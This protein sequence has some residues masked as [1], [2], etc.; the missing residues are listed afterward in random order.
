[1]INKACGGKEM[2]GKMAA[3]AKWRQIV[4]DLKLLESFEGSQEEMERLKAA[5]FEVGLGKER[6]KGEATK[7]RVAGT[8]TKFFGGMQQRS[9]AEIIRRKSLQHAFLFWR[10]GVGAGRDSEILGPLSAK[11][12]D[13]VDNYM[14]MFAHAFNKV[15][16][17]SS[18][19]A[20]ASVSV[21]HMV[22]GARGN[23]F[24]MDRKKHE[25]FTVYG[26]SVRRVSLG[27]GIV[28]HVARTGESVMVDMIMDERFDENVDGLLGFER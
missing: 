19:F 28:G 21:A 18:L 4:R 13:R 12:V 8:L 24:L 2:K 15:G 14:L 3:L 9:D 10:G 22:R 1:M 20:V 6:T 16:Q 23:L 7:M 5:M 27:M 11:D 26:A 17:I 25:L